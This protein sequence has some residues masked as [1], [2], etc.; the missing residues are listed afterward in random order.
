MNSNIQHGRLSIERFVC[1]MIEEN[2]YVVSDESGECVIVDCGA[3]FPE[4]RRAVAAYVV[5]NHLKPVHLISTHGHFDH[6]LGNETIFQRFLL[7]P[8][9]SA[10]DTELYASAAAQLKAMA[11][12]TWDGKL[13][14]VKTTLK[15]G[16]TISFGNHQLTVIETPGH[17]RGGLT[18]HCESEHVAF[19]GDTL[20]RGSIGRTDMPGGSMFQMIQTLRMLAQLP[21]DT[22]ILPGHGEPTTIGHELETNPYMDR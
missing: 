22:L 4:E 20:F 21:D 5:D 17:T 15:N 19:T 7:Q 18:F 6:N 16:D 12:T 10:K 13:P 2:C 3:F 8:E 14:E 1:N 11:G 9:M